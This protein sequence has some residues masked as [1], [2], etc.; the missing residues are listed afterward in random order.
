PFRRSSRNGVRC[1]ME[2]A[3]VLH[4]RNAVPRAAGG[5]DRQARRGLLG[6]QGSVDR[7]EGA[8]RG[9]LPPTEARDRRAEAR[10][11]A[12]STDLD[13]WERTQAHAAGRGNARRRVEL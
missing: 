10:P 3:R 11:E 9:S 7:A 5:A 8:L 1:W 4:V 6:A 13:R 12:I 2:R